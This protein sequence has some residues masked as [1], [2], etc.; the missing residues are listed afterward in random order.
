MA[1]SINNNLAK[2]TIGRYFSDLQFRLNIY[3]KAK[4]D[5]D[6]YLASSFNVFDYIKPNENALSDILADLLNQQ[7]KHGQKETFLQVFVELLRA[8]IPSDVNLCRVT[9]ESSTAYIDNN[10]RRMD[11]TLNFANS[12]MIAIENK[13]WAGEQENQLQDYQQHLARKFGENFCLV[14]ISGDGSSPESIEPILKDKLIAE[15][16]L[17]LL[18]YAGDIL[19][20]LERCYKECKAEKTRNFIKDFMHYIEDEFECSYDSE[21]ADDGGE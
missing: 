2:E 21:E 1:D 7:G 20:W 12:F 13:P 16:K 19:G 6:V 15:R 8:K 3:D 9:R 18:T 4:K 14:Y 17:V 10:Q 11:I 5:M